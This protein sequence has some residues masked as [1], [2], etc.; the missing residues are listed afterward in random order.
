MASDDQI[1]GYWVLRC[2][3][4]RLDLGGRTVATGLWIRHRIGILGESSRLF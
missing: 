4:M 1:D 2:V 3:G